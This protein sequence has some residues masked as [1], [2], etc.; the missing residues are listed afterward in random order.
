M[1][2]QFRAPPT[3]V[4]VT[5]RQYHPRR[6]RGWSRAGLV[7]MA[8]TFTVLVAPS[9]APAAAPPACDRAVYPRALLAHHSVYSRNTR[10]L[11]MRLRSSNTQ[12]R[13]QSSPEY[14]IRMRIDL[15]RSPSS[16]H[17]IRSYPK[18][19]VPVSFKHRETATVTSTYV[20]IHTEYEPTAHQVRCTRVVATHYKAP[21]GPGEP[22]YHR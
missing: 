4:G 20:E 3:S 11:Q 12:E 18:G 21:P 16:T 8:A 9:T 2:R 10:W 5:G 22:N 13:D 15:S 7:A 6:G 1:V 19:Q 14:P 17:M